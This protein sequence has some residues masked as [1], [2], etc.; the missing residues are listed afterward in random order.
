[1]IA[2][3]GSIAVGRNA[4]GRSARAGGWGPL[5]GDEGSAYAVALAA[6]RL[7]TRRAD[8][9]EP[10]P[11]RDDPLT[12]RLCRA[13]EVARP[14][15]IVTAIYAPGFDR[16][17]I[18]ALAPVVLAAAEQDPALVP[19][20]LEPAGKALAEMAA[21]VARALDWPAGPL[22][23]ALAGSFLLAAEAISGALCTGLGQTGYAVETTPVAEPVRG[24]LVLARQA[25]E[26]GSLPFAPSGAVSQAEAFGGAPALTRPSGTPDGIGTFSLSQGERV[27]TPRSPVLERL[28]ALARKPARTVV[29]LLSGTSADAIDV[30]VCRIS[31]GGVPRA[32]TGQPG[33]RVELLHYEEFPHALDVL[34]RLRDPDR[35]TP[36]DV[37]ELHVEVG[38]AFAAACLAAL[39]SA[40]IEPESVDLIGSHG[41][42]LYHHC[43][44][45]GSA[46]SSLQ[47]GDPDQIAERTGLPVIAEFRSRD[48]A[49]GGEGAPISPLADRILFAPRGG[50]PPGRRMVVNLGGIANVTVLDDDPSWIY[51]FDTG[52]ANSLIDRLAFVLSA[53]ALRYD[54]DGQFARQGTVDEALLEKLI[55][56]DPFLRKPPPKS[57]GFESYGDAF[58]AEA[59]AAHGRYDVALMATLTEF[60]ART[61][62]RALADFVAGDQPIDEIIL[63]GGGVRNPVLRS[64]IEALAAPT[65][66]RRSD[67]L[68]VPADAR[69]GMVFAVLANEA[70]LG[71]TTSLPRVTGARRPVILGRLAFPPA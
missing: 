60:T 23:L 9:R 71:N 5:I 31:G 12:N 25:L 22:P 34:R 2:G 35:L 57:T 65:R 58:L 24:A 50:A 32:G 17:R 45:P 18:A 54:R 15:E 30:A 55:E 64:R 14:A 36:R 33:A 41:Q 62:V 11:G 67:D 26:G 38:A 7:A 43:G 61:I 10:R 1:V 48:V 69:E 6:L 13:L 3:T 68:G 56:E 51:G 39:R 27:R 8:G 42:T 4:A 59:A 47:L 66:V 29:G 53:G 63:A 52:P 28:A 40:A 16:V 46:R 19:L 44:L 37:A 21:A 20:V 70:L 49:A